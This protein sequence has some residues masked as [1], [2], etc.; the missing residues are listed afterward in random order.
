[1]HT[2]F[3]S[4]FVSRLKC[5][6]L[7]IFVCIFLS[8][9]FMIT[10]RC[11]FPVVVQ[12]SA[13]LSSVKERQQAPATETDVLCHHFLCQTPLISA[14][15]S[16]H[17][18]FTSLCHQVVIFNFLTFAS[19]FLSLPVSSFSFNPLSPPS[20]SALLSPLVLLL[21][22]SSHETLI[23]CKSKRCRNN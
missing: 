1:M 17:K 15:L 5:C 9:I 14:L 23:V 6:L 13:P 19:F 12:I 2:F 8:I 22:L 4:G 18:H 20:R 11:S 21:Y 10:L 16:S 3:Q 7:S